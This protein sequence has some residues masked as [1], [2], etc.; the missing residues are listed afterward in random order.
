MKKQKDGIP[1]SQR[2]GGKLP[3]LADA[4]IDIVGD[5]MGFFQR[6]DEWHGASLERVIGKLGEQARTQSFRGDRGSVR[7]EKDLA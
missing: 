2:R 5:C 1:N 7:Q 6:V 4:A 3:G